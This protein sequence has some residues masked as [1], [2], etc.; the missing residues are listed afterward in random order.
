MEHAS[1][2]K[3]LHKKG[4]E[5]G[6]IGAL[7]AIVQKLEVPADDEAPISWHKELFNELEFCDD[8]TGA[9]LNKE[10]VIRA[11]HL[12]MSFFRKMGVYTKVPREKWMKVISTKWVDINKGDEANPNHRS[13]PRAQPEQAR[14]HLRRDATSGGVAVRAVSVRQQ[15]GPQGPEAELSGHD[16]GCEPRVLLRS[17][18]KTHIH[19]HPCRGQRGWR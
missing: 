9:M 8:L 16:L 18:H 7:M 11:R 6:Q 10:G 4:D 14:R 17:G 12:E 15:P 3:K 19:R 13:W 1:W 5:G 2:V